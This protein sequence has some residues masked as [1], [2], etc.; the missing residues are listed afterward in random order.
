MGFVFHPAINTRENSKHE[1]H[2][3]HFQQILFGQPQK[4]FYGSTSTLHEEYPFGSI[5]PN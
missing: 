3:T 5:Y 4:T 1:G 2:P